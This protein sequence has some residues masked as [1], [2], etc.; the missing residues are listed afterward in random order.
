MKEFSQIQKWTRGI[1]KKSGNLIYGIGDDCA[2]IRGDS[3]DILITT[4]AIVED[5]HFRSEWSSWKEVGYKAI[6]TAVSDIGA[7]GGVPRYLWTTV[8]I[9]SFLSDREMNDLGKGIQQACRKFGVIW[10]G[11][12]TVSHPDLVSISVTAWGEVA[13]GTAVL[14]RGAVPGD[15]IFVAGFLGEAA[16][17]LWLLQ[18]GK[19]K[20][21]DLTLL[22]KQKSPAPLL[23]VG[24]WLAKNEFVREIG[25]ASCRER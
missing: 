3:H 21:C 19:E 22:Q 11:G 8:Q 1:P 15:L 20:K 14:R 5:I 23:R 10:A 6:A 24:H 9:S 25:R 4:D 18:E 2:V 7:M 12:D 13:S 16:A 17:G